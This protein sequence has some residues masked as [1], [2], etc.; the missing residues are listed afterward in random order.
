MQT[1]RPLANTAIA[2]FL[3]RRI[4]ELKGAK[5]QRE[6]AAEAGYE[7]PNIISMFKYG[8]AKV[9]LDKIPA[10]A[11]ALE[12]DPAHLFRLALEQYWPALGETIRGDLWTHRDGE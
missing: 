11:K 10:L 3:D 8:E 5:T 1:V 2:R 7:K 4:D 6:I 12:I 9:P